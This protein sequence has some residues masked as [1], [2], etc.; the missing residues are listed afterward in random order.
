MIAGDK[1]CILSLEVTIEGY[2]FGWVVW[3]LVGVGSKT[4][5]FIDYYYYC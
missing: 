5:A 4:V 3:S 1:P 2:G